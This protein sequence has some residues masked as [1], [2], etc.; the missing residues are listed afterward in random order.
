M[1]FGNLDSVRDVPETV[2]HTTARPRIGGRFVARGHAIHIQRKFGSNIRG[3]FRVELIGVPVDVGEVVAQLV[4][5][6]VVGGTGAGEQGGGGDANLQE[7]VVVGGAA[8]FTASDMLAADGLG[9]K[10][11]RTRIVD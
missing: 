3:R 10:S 5:A 11:Q 4:V 1:V 7:T 9:E 2:L 8:K 6:G